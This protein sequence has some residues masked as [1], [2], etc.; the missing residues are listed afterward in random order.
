MKII[1][2]FFYINM[3]CVSIFRCCRYLL[4]I[5]KLWFCVIIRVVIWVRYY[6]CKYIEKFDK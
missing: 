3:Y 6:I 4:I 2:L 5:V 1:F